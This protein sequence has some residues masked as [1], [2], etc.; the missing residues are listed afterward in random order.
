MKSKMEVVN[1]KKKDHKFDVFVGSVVL[2]AFL[3]IVAIIFIFGQIQSTERK[4]PLLIDPDDL[5]LYSVG[6]QMIVI[7]LQDI[8]FQVYRWLVVK[9]S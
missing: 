4:A 8:V 1:V 5:Q 7:L 9:K 2:I 3:F 6:K